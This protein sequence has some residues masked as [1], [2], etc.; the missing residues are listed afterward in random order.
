MD[1]PRAATY[2]PIEDYAL[3]GDCRSA[4]LVARDG[5]IDWATLHRFD[6]DPVFCR[7]LDASRGGFWS[8]RPR[9]EYA[10]TR[11]YLPATNILRTVFTDARGSVALTDFMPVGRKLDA[12]VHD[13]VHLN[14]PGWIVRRIE[15]LQGEMELD[16]EYR[17][18]RRFAREPAELRLGERAVRAGIEM[19][20]L[21]GDVDFSLEG[22]LA[23]ATLRIAS[24]QTRDLV[25]ADS[26]VA[27]ESPLAR[28]DEFLK[29]TQAFWEE[30]I[31]YCRYRGPYQDTVMRSALALKMLTY[32]PTGAMVAAAT[33]SLPEEIGGERNWDYR[34]CWVR[35]SSFALYALAV[36]GYSGEAQCFDDY[37]LSSCA[38]S[39]PYVRPMYGIDGALQLEEKTLDHLEGYKGS[40]PVRT[41][42]GAYLQLQIDAYGQMLDL[43][44]MYK[45]LGGH[46]DE[47]YRRLLSAV[48][49]F[50]AAHWREPD[51]GIWEMRGPPRHHVHGKMMS[52]V[53][54]DRAAKL[55]DAK[56]QSEAQQI[57][58]EIC[59]R[60]GPDANE[61]L[62]QAYDGGTDAAVLLAPMLGFPLP[63]GTLERTVDRVRQVLG[64][65]DFLARYVGEDGLAGGEGEFLVCTSWLIDAELA[66]GRHEQ[67]RASIERLV[68]CAIDVGLYAEEVDAS[69]GAFLGNFPQALTHL[70]VIGNVVNLQLVERHG[71]QAL[72][73]SYASRARRA[74]TATFG[75]RGVL[76][77]MLQSGRVGRVFSSKH[78]KLAWP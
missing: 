17:P 6:A 56:W 28:A 41:G 47:Q 16:I 39:L 35:D 52:W 10:C 53:G 3:I 18:S 59:A 50:I 7:L 42:N 55:L 61:G 22:D 37:L 38:R 78:S 72:H 67:A 68:N 69:S 75:W 74:V 63:E 65:G 66:C 60:A 20:T 5:G 64:R 57:A 51:Q 26:V 36:L 70:G 76:A 73:G 21:Y 24:G 33:T 29:I 77:A 9:A 48:A 54:M 44:L 23:T 27:G 49:K 13:Y 45:T 11:A 34:Y 43:A 71:A 15:G 40:A 2:R 25:L 58:A 30:W 46:L 31:G 1:R 4:A 19:P 14:A 12:G 8:I 32:A 62:R